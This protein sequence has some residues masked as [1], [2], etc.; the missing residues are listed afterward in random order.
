MR[1]G[2]LRARSLTLVFAAAA[3]VAPIAA[4]A[5]NTADEAE[6]AFQR[7]NERYARRDYQDALAEYF[8]SYRLVPNRNVLFNIARCYE[9]LDRFNEAYRYYNDLRAADF[10]PEDRRQ[11]SQALARIRPKVALIHIS[12]E[13]SGADVFV[14]REDLGSRGQS[15]QTLALDPGR[16]LIRVKREG[17]RPA[18]ISVTLLRG[19][20]ME[21][22]FR[23]EQIVGTV[24]LTGKPSGAWAR[25]SPDGEILA[26][27]PGRL[28]LAPG[29]HV[30][31]IGHPG[32]GTAQVLVDVRAESA[33]P[34]EVSLVPQPQ[35]MGKVIVTANR[36]KALVRVDGKEAGFTPTVLE[37]SE[38]EHELE[39]SG[40]DL[41]SWSGQLKVDGDREQTVAA[42]LQYMGPAVK[43]ASKTLSSLD[44]APG[45]ITIITADEIRAFGYTTLAEALA[46]VRGFFTAD[47]R[48]YTRL[49]VRGFL[50]PGD[51]NTRVLILWDGHP[52][53]EVWSGEVYPGRE[54]NV[55]LEEVERIEVVRGP[56]SALYG[57]G[58]FFGVINLV[59]RDSLGKPS[60]EALG[61]VGALGSWRGHVTGSI[62]GAN[63][64]ALVS[65]AMYSAR[66]A[67][68]T[69][70][71][72]A[73]LALGADDEKAT[74]ASARARFGSWS[75]VAYFNQRQK[76]IPTTEFGTV[77]NHSG[78]GV[79]DSRS[80]AE[81]R[82]ERELSPTSSLSLRAYYDASRYRGTW[83]YADQD[84]T[85]AADPN[86]VL[87]QTETGSADW[88]GA[89]TRYRF[90]LFENNQLTMGAETQGRVRVEQ[91]IVGGPPG[92]ALESNRRILLAPYLLDEWRIHPKILLSVGL[93]I[94]KYL[95]VDVVPISPRLALSFWPYQRGLTKIVAG[96]AFRAPNVYELYYGDNTQRA[97]LRLNPETITTVELE[98]SHNISQEVRLTVAAYY[99]RIQQLVML[100]SETSSV[101]GCGAPREPKPCVVF[102]NAQDALRALGAEAGLR[103]QAGRYALLDVSY[104]YVTLMGTFPSIQAQTPNHLAAARLLLPIA[105]NVVRLSTQATYQSARKSPNLPTAT[106]EAL[107]LGFGLS[108]E[109]EHVRYY[110]GVSNLLDVTYA[111]PV[112]SSL[113]ISTVPQYGRSFLIQLSGGF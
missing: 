75:V 53:N 55:D 88:I 70:L 74:N 9:A 57:T 14:D 17:Y 78:T 108:G 100:A 107:L 73:G 66:G 2:V 8:L 82:Y 24:E 80:F 29:K 84:Q 7:G 85:I 64:S 49:G 102:Q 41:R 68:T 34:V 71:G 36:D 98:H 94:D 63:V 6:V 47:D 99:N 40:P 103:W 4:S 92:Q 31:Y 38:G 61:A 37:L 13:P 25:Q 52:M 69:D 15:P 48:V 43:A 67:R 1:F 23:L 32:F 65:A 93:R 10:P 18:E 3:L 62:Q 86:S 50:V 11:I 106:G 95:D 101:P 19:Q 89:E 35:A 109:Y 110:A 60:V 59:P 112:G 77:L 21:Q 91:A 16:H 22:A 51:T 45:S 5:D 56:G 20:E 87:V 96:Q 76:S 58:A 72:A 83:V 113:G 111:L 81:V 33:T 42:E 90:S 54:L 27:V 104:G 105:Q 26:T 28:Q 12:T 39:V 46:A 79:S 97:A 44:E 30:L